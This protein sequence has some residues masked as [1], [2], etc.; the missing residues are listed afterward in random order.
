MKLIYNGQILQTDLSF[1]CFRKIAQKYGMQFV[2]FEEG[3]WIDATGKIPLS[4]IDEL[5]SVYSYTYSIS[6][7]R[8]RFLM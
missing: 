4:Q 8:S 3:M 2:S 5:R 1:K 7:S 6:F